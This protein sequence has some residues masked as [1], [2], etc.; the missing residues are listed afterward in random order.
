MQKAQIDQR[1]LTVNGE[2]AI[3]P[4]KEL[5]EEETVYAYYLMLVGKMDRPYGP[6]LRYDSFNTDEFRRW[7]VG[8][9]YGRPHHAVRVLFNYEFRFEEVDVLDNGADDRLY[10]W[11]QVRF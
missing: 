4:T 9:Y 2:F 8:A 7:T 3:G 10:L 1:R 6:L 5:G 11:T